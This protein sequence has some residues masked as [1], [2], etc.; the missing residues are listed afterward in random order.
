MSCVA[1]YKIFWSVGQP[2]FHT[3]IDYIGRN[4]GTDSLLEMRTIYSQDLRPV[5][6]KTAVGWAQVLSLKRGPCSGTDDIVDLRPAL[7]E[8]CNRHGRMTQIASLSNRSVTH[9]NFLQGMYL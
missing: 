3:T 9:H 7:G 6:T 5:L 4:K 2:I 8:P 1:I